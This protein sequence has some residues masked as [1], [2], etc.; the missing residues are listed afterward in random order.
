M[1][2][3]SFGWVRFVPFGLRLVGLGRVGLDMYIYILFFIFLGGVGSSVGD[4]K[5]NDVINFSILE[6]IMY[7]TGCLIIGTTA[8]LLPLFGGPF[9]S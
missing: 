3:V 7:M 5:R 2:W 1:E 6:D 9:L 8:L 4:T